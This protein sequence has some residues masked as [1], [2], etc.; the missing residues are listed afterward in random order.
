MRHVRRHRRSYHQFAAIRMRHS[1]AVRV[2]RQPMQAVLLAKDPIVLAFAI[3]HIADERARQM[4]QVSSD[5]MQSSGFRTCFNQ[6]ITTKCSAPP[7]IG[8]CVDPRF[9]RGFGDG[10][11]EPHMVGRVTTGN[12]EVAFFNRIAAPGFG[13]KSRRARIKCQQYTTRSTTIQAVN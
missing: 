6:C 5:L 12:G 8:N 9:T 1:Q 4:F 2:Q 13:E 10:M 11:I 3:S 7:N